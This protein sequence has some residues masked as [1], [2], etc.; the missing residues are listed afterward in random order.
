[1]IKNNTYRPWWVLGLTAAL[2]SGNEF[3]AFAGPG[4]QPEPGSAYEAELLRLQ[5]NHMEY[6]ELEGLNQKLLRPY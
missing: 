5:D 4:D 1:M 2:A 3:P 6:D